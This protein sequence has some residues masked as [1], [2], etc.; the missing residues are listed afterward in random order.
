ML[1]A[2]DVNVM[3]AGCCTHVTGE[4][5]KISSRH[6]NYVGPNCIITVYGS[7]KHISSLEDT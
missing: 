7:A 4:A 5:Q 6:E 1:I 3:H 2:V